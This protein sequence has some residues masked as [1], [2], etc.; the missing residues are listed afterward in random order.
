MAIILGHFFYI[1]AL[2][3]DICIKWPDVQNQSLQAG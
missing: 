2:L 1:N 3:L